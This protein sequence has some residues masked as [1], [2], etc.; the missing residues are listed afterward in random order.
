MTLFRG[1]AATAAPGIRLARRRESSKTELKP[2][3][4]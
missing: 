2:R 1:N 4:A 3:P